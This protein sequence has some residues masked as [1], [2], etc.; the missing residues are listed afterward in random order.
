MSIGKAVLRIRQK[1][2]LTQKEVGARA[3]LAT[4]YVSR[5]ENG[6]IQPTMRT[7]ARLAKALG[8]PTSELFLV[9]AD[10]AT[11][12]Q[13]VCPVTAS[14]DC[15][16][17]LIRSEHGRSPGSSRVRYGKEELRLLRMANYLVLHG[18]RDVR[19]ALAVLLESLMTQT[20]RE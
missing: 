1:Q 3:G 9:S 5:I 4:S 12:R 2:G 6:H 11:S 13:H 18:S 16:G 19:R 8:V 14:G 15:I 10:K 20:G 17:E 7:L